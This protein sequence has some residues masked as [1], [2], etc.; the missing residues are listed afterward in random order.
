M[1]RRI[2]E[3][4]DKG[5]RVEYLSSKLAGSWYCGTVVKRIGNIITVKRSGNG[6]RKRIHLG[7]VTGYWPP[8]VKASPKNRVDVKG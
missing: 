8:R 1:A 2:F 4:I 7:L 6:Q 3:E 5:I